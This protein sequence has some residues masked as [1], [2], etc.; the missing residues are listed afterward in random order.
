MFS[1][2]LGLLSNPETVFKWSYVVKAFPPRWALGTCT[3]LCL[4]T[5]LTH[6]CQNQSFHVHIRTQ[7][8][9]W[10]GVQIIKLI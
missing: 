3:H 10:G 7:Y 1:A 6:A 2:R 5:K 9:K 4:K 8:W